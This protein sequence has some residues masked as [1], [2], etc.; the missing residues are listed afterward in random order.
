MRRDVEQRP[1]GG[2]NLRPLWLVLSRQWVILVA[3][4]GTTLL[5]ALMGSLLMTKEYQAVALVQLMPRAGREVQLSSSV[6]SDAVGYMEM[7]DRART[8]IQIIQS[9]NVREEVLRRYGQLGRGDVAEGLDGVGELGGALS[10]G[11]REDTQL[12]EIRVRHVDP[13]SAAI[14]ANLVAEVYTEGNLTSRTDAARTARVWL[15]D[16]TLAYKAEVEEAS[17]ALLAFKEANDV[18]DIESNVDAITSRRD[19]LQAALGEAAAERSQLEGTL[20]EHQRLLKSGS[21][22]VLAGMLDDPGLTA[23]LRERATITTRYAD[24]LARYGEQ[25]PEHKQAVQHIERIDALVAEEV[26]SIVSREQAQLRELGRQEDRINGELDTIRVELLDKER[27]RDAYSELAMEQER[28]Q[29]LYA[30][31]GERGA[32]VDLEASSRLNDVR[33]VDPALPPGRPISPNIP[34]NLAGALV[35]GLS[36]G[37]GLAWIRERQTETVLDGADVEQLGQTLLGALPT[38]PGSTADERAFY[39]FDRPRSLVAESFRSM[40]AVLLT[41][42]GRGEGRSIVVT[43]SLPGEGK[44]HC[45]VG[46]AASFAQLGLSTVLVDADLRRPRLHKLFGRDESP[47]LTEALADGLAPSAVAQK[48]HVPRLEIVGPGAPAESPTE[49]LASEAMRAFLVQLRSE[50]D[51][52]LIDTAPAGL[53]SD[54][55]ALVGEADGILLIVRRGHAP[56]ELVEETLEQLGKVGARL[57]GVGLNDMP[58]SR[59]RQAYGE[60]YYT[61]KRRPGARRSGGDDGQPSS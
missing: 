28:A 36:G 4:L 56:R 6:Q 38:I 47:G 34:L 35:L 54:A 60:G 17:E 26:E 50:Y 44:T 48:T 57:L 52:V 59:Q 5:A 8:Q 40:R 23:M 27:L 55:V 21:H 39:H 53:T 43:S 2:L 24:V 30:S 1:S 22:D 18:V 58:V 11:P 3:F 16:K 13:E 51:V 41:Q 49:L 61:D 32:E 42:P 31:L 45:C 29:R 20:G 14:L 25:H 46:L 9:R 15:D 10:A 12:V 33:L 7:R 37:L 19:A